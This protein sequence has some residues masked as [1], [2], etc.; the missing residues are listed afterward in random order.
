V[1]IRLATDQD[2]DAIHA[3]LRS[4]GL[5]T[6]DLDTARPLFVVAHEGAALIGTAAL[7][8][9][10]AAALVRSVAVVP[11]ARNQGLGRALLEKLEAH[12]RA[13]GIRQLVLLTETAGPFFERAGYTALDRTSAPP[14]VQVSAE[15]RSLCPASATCM[16]KVLDPSPAQSP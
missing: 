12:A 9:H 14:A 8:R 10:G 4:A 7:E 5:P 2:R 1:E 11:E 13:R 16:S 15:F 6:A 3:I